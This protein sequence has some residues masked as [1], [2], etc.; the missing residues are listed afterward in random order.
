MEETPKSQGR[1]PSTRGPAKAEVISASTTVEKRLEKLRAT[2]SQELWAKL[3]PG[4]KSAIVQLGE[5]SSVGLPEN[6]ADHF[7]IQL[8][9]YE[10]LVARAVDVFGDE[11]KAS[12][13]L[14]L[15]NSELSGETPLQVAKRDGYD[16]QVLEPIFTRIE[17]GIYP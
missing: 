5:K 4:R 13:W 10:Q 9:K 16:R 15:P 8:A 1:R 3:S 17:H 12:K 11:I 14:S 6:V 7:P 2:L